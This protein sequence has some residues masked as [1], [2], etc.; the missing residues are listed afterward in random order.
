MEKWTF[1]I[2][3]LVLGIP[4]S[5]FVNLTTPSLGSY[6]KNRSLSIRERKIKAVISGYKVYR[7][8]KVNPSSMTIVLLSLIAAAL[9]ILAS[10][11]VF[12]FVFPAA[13]T[14]LIDLLLLAVVYFM[15]SR[16]LTAVEYIRDFDRFKE[17]TVKKLVKQRGNPEDL[18]K[19]DKE[20]E[21]PKQETARK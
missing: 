13:S 20:F 4:I 7:G 1:L 9:A 6:L 10:M 16:I 8:Y 2:L 12:S 21:K 14:K 15:A 3:G 18:D 5:Y 17:Q 19:I 11:F